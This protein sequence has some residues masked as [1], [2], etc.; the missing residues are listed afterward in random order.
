MGI[1]QSIETFIA[2]ATSAGWRVERRDE[3]KALD[4]PVEVIQR[5]G[6]LPLGYRE[7]LCNVAQATSADEGVWFLSER[8]FQRRTPGSFA[9]NEIEKMALDSA[10]HDADR[11]RVASFWDR[12]LPIMMAPDGDYDYL[13]LALADAAVVHGYDPYWEEVSRVT[14]SFEDWLLMFAK[15]L[16]DPGSNP[17]APLA[18]RIMSQSG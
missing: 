5:Y 4:L 6:L 7:F 10:A 18:L 13:A 8:D 16:A 14:D 1:R 17:N 11:Q 3:A 9:W 15:E 2:A 12:H